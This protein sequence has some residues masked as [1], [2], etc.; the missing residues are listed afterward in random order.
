[1]WLPSSFLFTNASNLLCAHLPC[2]RIHFPLVHHV[3][4]YEASM[5]FHVVRTYERSYP[6]LV[7]S[8]PVAKIQLAGYCWGCYVGHSQAPAPASEREWFHMR[9]L[10]VC[11]LSCIVDKTWHGTAHV[12]T[13]YVVQ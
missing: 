8:R 12:A 1:M 2:V 13:A 5:A 7:C 11:V 9:G 4:Y 10:C 3:F 6:A